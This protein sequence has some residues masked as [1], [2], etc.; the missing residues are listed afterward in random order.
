MVKAFADPNHEER[1][2]YIEWL[3]APFDPEAF[4]LKAVN[5]TLRR[6]Q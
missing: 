2:S 5:E 1:E 6:I 3:G 4:D